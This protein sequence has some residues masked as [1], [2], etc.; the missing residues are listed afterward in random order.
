MDSIGCFHSHCSFLSILI[1]CHPFY[2]YVIINLHSAKSFKQ[3]GITFYETH[4]RLVCPDS[5]T[6][7]HFGQNKNHRPTLL[8]PKYV[9]I[10]I[11]GAA[12]AKTSKCFLI[13][14]RSSPA[15]IRK[16]TRPK[17]AGACKK[18]YS[19]VIKYLLKSPEIRAKVEIQFITLKCT[20]LEGIQE[21]H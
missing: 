11:T 4:I 16:E 19:L 10:D 3:F 6:I 15:C 8:S 21:E 14:F 18:Q 1:L 13:R 17:A 12:K 5:T 2:F 20:E 7:L 9:T